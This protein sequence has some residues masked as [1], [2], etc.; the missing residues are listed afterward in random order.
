MKILVTGGKGFIG[1]KIVEMLSADHQVTVVDNSDTYNIMS[2]TELQKLYTWR[3]RN[4]NSKNVQIIDGDVL[5]RLVCLKAFSH[6]PDIVIHLATYPRAKIVDNDPILGIPK[7]IN[8]T[9]NLLWHSEKWNVRKF[10]YVS[11]SMVY[12][13]F[14]DGMKED[15]K[16]KP[17]N[18]Y[19]EA[20]LT[21]E[22]LVKLFS[23]RDGLNYNIIRPSGVYGPGDM[24]DRVVS[25]FFDKAMSNQAI[26]LHNGD[27]KVDFTYR[28]DAARGIILAALS[29]VA[30]VSF[31]IT[32]GKAT[33]LRKLAEKIIA[34]T[35]SDS[36]IEDTGN[37]V[38]YPM[39]GTLDISRA[40]DLL[41][42][43]PEFTLDEGLD[44]YYDW[45]KNRN[46]V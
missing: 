32:A 1:S 2:N 24:P 38:L 4:W 31:N 23:K 44:S 8:T 20:K 30:N 22:R 35:G 40:S 27:N 26:T 15:G 10:V 21:G 14:S 16:T 9:T 34:L 28:R 36:D 17:K 33:S 41:D 19:G 25:K 46:G 37:H 7:V 43:K 6:N 3:M 45:L 13:D 5:D 39:R 12:G 11:S 18:I 29:P 42:Y